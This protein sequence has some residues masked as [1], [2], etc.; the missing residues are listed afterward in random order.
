[1]V[2]CEIAESSIMHHETSNIRPTFIKQISFDMYEIIDTFIRHK[3]IGQS[4][5][6]NEK[7]SDSIQLESL[8]HRAIVANCS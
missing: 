8:D 6:K 2:N 7:R 5:K 4:N 1:M 3:S